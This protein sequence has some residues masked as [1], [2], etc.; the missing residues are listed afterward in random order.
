MTEI[1]SQFSG[2]FFGDKKGTLRVGF[3]VGG[4]RVIAD[5]KILDWS[6][7]TIRFELPDGLTGAFVLAVRSE[8]GTGLALLTLDGGVVG[9]VAPAPGWQGGEAWENANGV[10]YKSLSADDNFYIFSS[11]RNDGYTDNYRLE[12]SRFD[13]AKEQFNSMSPPSAKTQAPIQPLVVTDSSGKETLWVFYTGWTWAENTCCQE[14]WYNT[15]YDPGT[16]GEWGSFKT[17][18]NVGIYEENT[19]APVYDPIKHRIS[20]YY[21]YDHKLRWVYTD[22]YGASW[23]DDAL[24]GAESG[25]IPIINNFVNAI[26]WPS[27]TTTALVASTGQVIAVEDG[28]YRGSIGDLN[29]DTWRPSL[30]D[31]GG[32]TALLYQNHAGGDNTPTIAKL[33]YATDA[34]RTWTWSG[35]TPLVTLPDTGVPLTGY[36]FRWSPYGGVAR[37]GADR[38]LYVFYGVSLWEA[39]TE[40]T[41][42]RWYLLDKGIV[43]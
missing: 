31:L 22:D 30:V 19:V 11:K 38:H 36:N 1:Q 7:N 32:E 35:S 28:E 43:G 16:I 23:S 41:V 26:Y 5:P 40:E 12:G 13:T 34:D 21:E 24:V 15:Y 27:A 2:Q 4:E 29:D 37:V 10:Y 20:V 14:I 17:I 39:Y 8:V 18:P 33:K 42:E 9:S 25:G 6:M 3:E